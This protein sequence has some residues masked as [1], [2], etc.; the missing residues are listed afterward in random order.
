MKTIKFSVGDEIYEITAT[1]WTDWEGTGFTFWE[2][3]SN[4]INGIEVDYDYF[5]LN[6]GYNNEYEFQQFVNDA[7][8]YHTYF[9]MNEDYIY[10]LSDLHNFINN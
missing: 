2:Q 4:K 10:S 6:L 7:F 3:I 5:Y 9:N 8:T 1:A